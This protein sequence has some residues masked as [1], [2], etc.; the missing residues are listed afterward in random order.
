ML[1]R[2]GFLVKI[3]TAR[4]SRS[5]RQQVCRLRAGTH[6]RVG[7]AGNGINGHFLWDDGAI[8]KSVRKKQIIHGLDMG[9]EFVNNKEHILHIYYKCS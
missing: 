5:A 7:C 8:R 3:K 4:V 6:T 1:G 2:L 9:M